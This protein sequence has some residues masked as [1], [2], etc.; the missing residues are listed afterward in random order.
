[1]A[2][3][4]QAMSVLFLIMFVSVL[5]EGADDKKYIDY[6][7]IAKHKCSA[8]NPQNCNKGMQKP[9]PGSA[10]PYQRGCSATTR[11]RT[12]QTTSRKA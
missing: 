9:E 3:A 2:A 7:A 4:F 6:G 11:C 8:E 10:N 1:M 12:G 5:V